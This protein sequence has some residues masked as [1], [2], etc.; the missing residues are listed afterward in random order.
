MSRASA[1]S[2]TKLKVISFPVPFAV[3]SKVVPV[4]EN[5][6]VVF[7]IVVDAPAPEAKVVVEL[8]ESVV[9]AAVEGVVVPIAVEFIPVEVVLKLAEVTIKSPKELVVSVG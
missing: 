4:K 6:P 1:L 3:K 5:I 9:K 2:S 8:E 7:P